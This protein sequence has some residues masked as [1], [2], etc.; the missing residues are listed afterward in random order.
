MSEQDN[1][2]ISGRGS[3]QKSDGSRGT[4][5][6][7]SGVSLSQRREAVMTSAAPPPPSQ[8]APWGFV[9]HRVPPPSPALVAN[10]LGQAGH[11]G[12]GKLGGTTNAPA[13][14][15]SDATRT[16]RALAPW[17]SRGRVEK[18]LHGSCVAGAEYWGWLEDTAPTRLLCTVGC[19]QGQGLHI[20]VS[21]GHKGTD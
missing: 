19:P 3:G 1:F 21:L 13:S 15:I 4:E 16:P 5:R 7:I 14:A 12:T 17:I 6:N 8:R 10:V 18:L 20:P 2:F 11:A 9:G